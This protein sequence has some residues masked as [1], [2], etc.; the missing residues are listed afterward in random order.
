MSGLVSPGYVPSTGTEPSPPDRRRTRRLVVASVLWA[1][2]L[3][4]LTWYSVRTDPPTV[5]EQRSLSDAG[6][7]VDRAIGELAG[8]VGGDLVL[9]LTPPE[10]E[11]GCRVTPLSDGGTLLRGVT[12]VV[13]AGEERAL[14]ERVSGRLPAD[15]RAGV[16]VTAEGP[17]LRADAG[18]FVTVEGEVEREGRVRFTADTGCR[19]VGDGYVEPAIGAGPG[20]DVDA[21]VA[22]LR[23]VGHPDQPVGD[24]DRASCPDGGVARTVRAEPVPAPPALGAALAPLSGG[25]PV[26]DDPEV[27]AYRVGTVGVIAERIDD[28]I[29]LSATDTC[30]G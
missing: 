21:L 19:P 17:R 6:P 28:R 9:T 16:R 10:V 5:R 25:A 27:Y 12:V 24:H 14:L 11:R 23:A 15:W 30:A 3:A 8:A 2:L 20:P 13:P 22:A 4:A 1:V 26:V 18:E 7:V 29:R